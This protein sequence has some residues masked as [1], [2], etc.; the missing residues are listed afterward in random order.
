AD[1]TGR[2]LAAPQSGK[3][4]LDILRGWL[5]NRTDPACDLGVVH[6]PGT[7]GLGG[8]RRNPGGLG[9]RH[10]LGLPCLRWDPLTSPAPKTELCVGPTRVWRARRAW[11]SRRGCGKKPRCG[12]PSTCDCGHRFS[13]SFLRPRAAAE[14]TTKAK[15]A[16]T[17]EDPP[18]SA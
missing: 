8:S 3:E 1:P 6:A 15:V 12:L 7:K 14:T 5:C 18:P 13:S 2:E 4:S 9:C 10:S 11:N 17:L 16:E